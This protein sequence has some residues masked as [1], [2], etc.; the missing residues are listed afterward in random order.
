MGNYAVPFLKDELGYDPI[1][2]LLH[3]DHSAT[4]TCQYLEMRKASVYGG[5][6]EIQKNIIAKM[7]LEL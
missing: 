3:S 1:E 4:S 6:N 7:I 5:S 2:T